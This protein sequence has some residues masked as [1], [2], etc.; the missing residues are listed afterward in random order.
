MIQLSYWIVSL[1]IFLQV[2]YLICFQLYNH[3]IG[4]H[5]ANALFCTLIAQVF[6]AIGM[7][8]ACIVLLGWWKL[9]RPV[10]NRTFPSVDFLTCLKAVTV[11][12][13]RYDHRNV[14][15]SF[16]K[17]KLKKIKQFPFVFFRWNSSI[18]TEFLAM[19]SFLTMV[20]SDCFKNIRI[21][22]NCYKFIHVLRNFWRQVLRMLEIY[23]LNHSLYCWEYRVESR[24]KQF[25]FH[26][27][28]NLISFQHPSIKKLNWDYPHVFGFV[29]IWIS[30]KIEYDL[31]CSSIDLVGLAGIIDAAQL[32]FE[33][34]STDSVWGL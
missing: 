15:C 20:H 19:C 17:S 32:L 21:S 11:S 24:L 22:V 23:S 6:D 4:L 27:V 5:D 31:S 1:Q 30:K 28:W 8:T 7:K 16:I 29:S 18:W 25:S 26:Q 12:F 34:K 33:G 10:D 14:S 2:I 3:I 13:R 9:N